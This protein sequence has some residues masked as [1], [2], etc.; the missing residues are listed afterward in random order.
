MVVPARS[1]P[2]DTTPLEALLELGR[3]AGEETLAGVLRA[4]AETI[5]DVAGFN[6]VVVNIYRPA[7][8][9]YEVVMVVG[10][11]ESRLALVGTAAPSETLMHLFS[12]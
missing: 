9:D 2:T 5:R 1:H 11:E 3:C 6:A 10:N 12:C 4:V 7:W 8:D